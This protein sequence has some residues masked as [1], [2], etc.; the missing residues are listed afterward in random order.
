MTP[1]PESTV[2]P[3]QT[4]RIS[5]PA[6]AIAVAPYLLG[7]H[8]SQSLVLIAIGEKGRALKSVLRVD[9]PRDSEEARDQATWLTGILPRDGIRRVLLLGYGSG[10]RVTPIM[11]AAMPA[12]REVGVSVL[13]ALRIEDGRYWSYLCANPTCCPS[14]GVPFDTLGSLPAAT[15]VLVGLTALSDRE[16]LAA[17]LE[18]Q[19]SDEAEVRSVTAEVCA[20]TRELGE[21]RDW[22]GDGEKEIVAALDRVQAGKL[23]DART[24]AWLGARLSATPV[25]DIAVSY[26]ASYDAETHVRLWTEVVRKVQRSFVPAPASLLAFA[27]LC[28]GNGTLARMALDRAL[29]VKPDYSLAVLLTKALSVGLSPSRLFSDKWWEQ[30][31]AITAQVRAWPETARPVLPE[32]W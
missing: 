11:D 13:D 25:R 22:F 5:K 21:E 15:A 19:A 24:A 10:S 2:N 18:P 9:L 4:I 14:E 12:L 7:F 29:S 1:V 26:L 3:A 32:G 23:I 17:T 8:P 28:A 27:A 6:D 30:T 20:H 16:A 31:E